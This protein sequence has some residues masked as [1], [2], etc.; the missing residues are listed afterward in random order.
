MQDVGSVSFVQ[1]R[2]LTFPNIFQHQVQPFKLA[3]PS[4][5][6]HRKILAFFLVDPNVRVLSTAHVPVQRDWWYREVPWDKVM[7]PLPAELRR[8][9]AD[10]VGPEPMSME[11]A[12]KVREELMEERKM[13][14]RENQEQWTRM[15]FSLCEH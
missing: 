15:E 3:D 9:V 11:E 6:G 14:V 13:F 12:K 7:G 5:P 2:L 10:G 4:K 1:G 8:I